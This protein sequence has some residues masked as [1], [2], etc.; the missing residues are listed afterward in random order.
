D[1]AGVVAAVWVEADERDGVDA[2]RHR[3]RAGAERRVRAARW[4]E[5]AHGNTVDEN[6]ERLA[7]ALE[8]STLGGAEP[9]NVSAG[10]ERHGLAEGAGVLQEGDLAALRGV[11]V[12]RRE[13]AAIAGDAGLAHEVPRRARG[14]I[15]VRGGAGTY[16]RRLE[17]TVLQ[18]RRRRW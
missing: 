9:N 4:R 5:R 15:L 8:S 2:C 17:T 13:A 3:E 10:G 7:A 16:G 1:E 6:L 18:L 14:I 11:G 12:A